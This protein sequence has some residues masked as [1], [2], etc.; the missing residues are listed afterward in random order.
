MWPW[1]RLWKAP[2]DLTVSAWADANRRLS[3]ESSP[4]PF[5][6]RTA[7]A[8]YQRGIMDAFS[9]PKNRRVVVM[10]SAQVGKTSIVEN[11]TGFHMDQ[12]PSPILIVEPTLDM[13]KPMSK[14]RFAPMF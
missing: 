1:M 4:E 11:V 2:P 5:A 14:D 6:W 13:G 12:D 9:D 3:S 7:R 8:E 10:S